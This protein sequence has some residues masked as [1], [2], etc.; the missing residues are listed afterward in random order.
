MKMRVINFNSLV[1]LSYLFPKIESSSHTK[2]TNFF[3]FMKCKNNFSF[4]NTS[5]CWKWEFLKPGDV[6]YY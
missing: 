5:K 3:Y 2:R 1:G 6:A 4:A